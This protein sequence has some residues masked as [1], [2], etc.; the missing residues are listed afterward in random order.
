LVAIISTRVSSPPTSYFFC[1]PSFTVSCNAARTCQGACFFV[2]SWLFP[3]SLFFSAPFFAPTFHPS[4]GT[5]GC[6]AQR[7]P[8]ETFPQQAAES[9]KKKHFEGES[10]FFLTFPPRRYRV[11]G[12]PR[13]YFC[14]MSRFQYIRTSMINRI[15]IVALF[16]PFTYSPLPLRWIPRVIFF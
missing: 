4:P 16:F 12:P 1:T 10:P 7:A 9:R 2:C 5:P 6:P 14:M 8:S 15:P 3:Y 13:D 11:P